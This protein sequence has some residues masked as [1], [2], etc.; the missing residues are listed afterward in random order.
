[1]RAYFILE[2]VHPGVPEISGARIVELMRSV[3]VC[4]VSPV[5]P[6]AG[7]MFRG[8]DGNSWRVVAVDANGRTAD[9]ERVESN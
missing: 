9:V 5:P 2:H 4:L 1:M 8:N 6:I 7:A 3:D